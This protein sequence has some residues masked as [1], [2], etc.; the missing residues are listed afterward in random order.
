MEHLEIDDRLSSRQSR[1]K[2]AFP[3]FKSKSFTFSI[4]LIQ[5]ILYTASVLIDNYEIINPTEKSLLKLGAMV[6]SM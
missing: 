6:N 5:I 3:G 2:Q 1:I 4:T